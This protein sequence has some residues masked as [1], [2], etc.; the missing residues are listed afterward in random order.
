M[1]GSCRAEQ[2]FAPIAANASGKTTKK[3][4]VMDNYGD[5][6]QLLVELD[7]RHDELLRE[8]DELDK[9]VESVLALWLADR[10]GRKE[11]A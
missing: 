6:L 4:Q 10:E 2:Q 1:L 5:E 9:K 7:A 8:L 3:W 11:A